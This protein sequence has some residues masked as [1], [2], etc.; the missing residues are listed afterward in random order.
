MTHSVCCDLDVLWCWALVGSWLG[1]Q[2]ARGARR[3]GVGH[4]GGTLGTQAGR[5]A[6]RRQARVGGRALQAGGRQAAACGA[7]GACA[8]G[9]RQGRGLGA[10]L[11]AW[12]LGARASLGQC[13]RPIFDPF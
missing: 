9:A 1:A 12:A 8:A 3:R 2:S 6:R 7:G 4:A 11:A 13:T 5:W 10:G